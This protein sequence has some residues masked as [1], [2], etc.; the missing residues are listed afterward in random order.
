[1]MTGAKFCHSMYRLTFVT[2]SESICMHGLRL[3]FWWCVTWC[4]WRYRPLSQV[5]SSVKVTSPVAAVR[6]GSG[7]S[8]I[9][10]TEQS[11]W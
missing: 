7:L 8:P 10:A 3:C 1:M 5:A 9:Y 4:Q 6:G 2:S 11:P